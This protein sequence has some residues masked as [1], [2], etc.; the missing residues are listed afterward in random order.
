M[1]Y[2][3]SSHAALGGNAV[4]SGHKDYVGVGP[5][6]FARLSELTSGDTIEVVLGDGSVYRYGV[7]TLRLVPA[8]PTQA[9]IGAIVGAT[10]DPVVTLITPGGYFD[11][12]SDGYD[13]RLIVRAALVQ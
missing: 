13:Q 4:F 10:V 1:W 2:D 5:A 12:A 11:P 7:T 6:V 8:S 3:F 9:E